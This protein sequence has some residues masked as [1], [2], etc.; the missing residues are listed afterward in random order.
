MELCENELANLY[1]LLSKGNLAE[2]MECLNQDGLSFVDVGRI[3]I[4][5]N[6]EGYASPELYFADELGVIQCEV[7]LFESR[8]LYHAIDDN[9][10]YQVQGGALYLRY[11]EL[12]GISAYRGVHNY[13]KVPLMITNRRIGFVE[14]INVNEQGWDDPDKQF[15]W[16]TNM[17]SAL[18]YKMIQHD[19]SSQAQ[20]QLR[21]ERLQYQM[22]V[23]LTNSV[24]SRSSKKDL[25]GALL[26][27]LYQRFGMCDLSIIQSSDGHYGQ[28]SCSYVDGN[29][30][31]ENHCFSHDDVIKVAV[32]N[33]QPVFLQQDAL[34]RL[35]QS[36][37]V[38]YFPEA[39]QTVC[40]FPLIFRNS[41]IGYICYISRVDACYCMKDIDLFG[42]IAARVALAMHSLH[43][44]TE[45][46]RAIPASEYVSIEESYMDYAIFDEVISQ[47]QVMN[48]VLDQLA[49]VAD[50]DSTV[51]I[52][53]ESGTGKELIAKAIH[54]LSRRSHRPMIK[55]NCA[56]IPVGLFE[57]ELFGHERGAFSGAVSQRIG[58]FEQAHKG[59]L[60]LDE[61]GD[62]P[63]ELQPKLLRALQEN[64]IERVG[65]N[66]LIDVDV[67][68][69]V[70]TNQDLFS[71]VQSKEFR[72]DLFYRLNV[73]PIEI[74]ALRERPE[75]IPLLIKHFT[76]VIS[77]KMGKNINR[78]AASDL[79]V[80]SRFSWPGN[81]RE[82]R[83]FIERSVILT[84]GD[85][86]SVPIDDLT[87]RAFKMD[88]S[89][90]L[91]MSEEASCRPTNV[92]REAIIEALRDCNG[93]IAGPRGAANRL[94]VKRTTLLSRM[95]KMG[96]QSHDYLSYSS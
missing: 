25:M 45:T 84:R 83:N 85:I 67:R 44:F 71:M 57:S 58:R 2:L 53:G 94:S 17:V 90:E 29:L 20:L 16:F 49:M 38:P 14:Y 88:A 81:V 12:L 69:V 8:Q 28:K 42:Q 36:S 65:K 40:V 54:K 10:I 23:D 79:D 61:I 78:I 64:E 52:L 76:R 66:L 62:M 60:F 95:K 96:I 5:L 89:A 30:V 77:K 48:H 59:T 73:F 21:D 34:R 35:N 51:L 9:E 31:F 68:I 50:C 93:V 4:V 15:G 18:I 92:D 63:L 47:S 87:L 33:N 41:T 22:L 43:V 82:L 70:A 56:A 55:M 13:C 19:L 3:N 24:I 6:R 86:L 7:D 46:T 72:D 75:D 39:A 80:M 11:P 37:N 74:P 91:A 27:F 32:T 1:K 26:E